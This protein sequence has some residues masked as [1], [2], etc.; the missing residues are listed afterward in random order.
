[1]ADKADDLEVASTLADSGEHRVQIRKAEL[2]SSEQFELLGVLGVGGMGEV[3][4]AY[5]LTLKRHVALKIL[6]GATPEL[7]ERLMREAQAQARVEHQNVCRVHGVG[8]IDGHPF[9]AL[10]YIEGKTL[11]EIGRELA[12]EERVRVMKDVALGLHAAHR[13]GLIHR[14]VK[15]ANILM[16]R[17]ED[18]AWKPYIADFGIARQVEAAA[19]TTTNMTSG[20]PLY[21]A[22]EQA[23]GDARK[24]DRRTDVYSLGA[25]LYELCCGRPPFVGPTA[26]ALILSVVAEEAVALRKREPSVPVDLETITMK[27]L[28]KDPQR[29][30]E[31]ARALAE[32]L[33]R[34]LDGEPILARRKSWTYR[35]VKRARKHLGLVVAASCAL[36][37][38]GVAAAV[39][40]SARRGAAAQA[41]LAQEV[42]RK[43]EKIDALMRYSALLPRHDTRREQ[44]LIRARMR[45]IEDEMARAAEIARPPGHY[46]LGR[47][48]LA[49]RNHGEAERHLRDAWARGYRAPEVAYA[50]GLVLGARYQEAMET[51]SHESEKQPRADLE[52][53]AAESFRDPALAFLKQSA[54]LELDTPEYAEA[55]M[56]LY[57]KRFEI[58]SEKARLAFERAPWLFEAQ[59]LEGDIRVLTAA[60]RHGRGDLEGAKA[61]LE[62]AGRAYTAAIAT[63]PSFVAAYVGNCRRWLIVTDL[64]ADQDRSPAEAVKAGVAACDTALETLPEDAMLAARKSS[65]WRHL[66]RYEDMHGEDPSPTFARAIESAAQAVKWDPKLTRAHFDEG[67]AH[68]GLGSYQQERGEDP[69][70]ALDRAQR[71]AERILA[72]DPESVEG[73]ELMAYTASTLADYQAA[74]GIDPRVELRRTV[75]HGERA[76]RRTPNAFHV[77]NE[78]GTAWFTLA[79]YELGIGQDPR[80]AIERA[81]PIY[82][83]VMRTQPTL[84]FGW[85]NACGVLQTRAEYE[86][87]TGGDPRPSL[88]EAVRYCQKAIDL[89]PNYAGS[90]LNLGCAHFDRA[91][92]EVERGLDPSG[93]IDKA[94]AALQAAIA[95]DKDY[96]MGWR[97]IAENQLLAARHAMAQ[98]KAPDAAFGTARSALDRAA[99]INPKDSDVWRASA[100]WYRHRAEWRLGKKQSIEDDV[101]SGL[102]AAD[103]ALLINPQLGPAAAIKGALYALGARAETDAARRATA[104]N[105]A[106]AAFRDALRLNPLVDHDHHE[107]IAEVAQD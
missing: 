35:A 63:A 84:D 69:R 11:R 65:M 14:D 74:R 88:D 12:L 93:S 66:A 34:Y 9:I 28:E 20:T 107:L 36:V 87:R 105:R 83:E 53:Q 42:G 3:H 95:V 48:Y 59:T 8:T 37:I 30:Y 76:L 21:M 81:M 39:A 101:R 52:R 10:Q 31:T 51:A 26:A 94:H 58:A 18:G 29:R 56:A 45:E 33:Q 27:C 72:I 43:V 41:R 2:L 40:L 62:S 97:Y 92:Y 49:L 103:K 50:L 75:E 102:A 73:H 16:E 68:R 44:A 23:R 77:R 13:Q 100:E 38:A 104:R 25:T 15:P 106:R 17:G 99:S 55:L 5:D 61:D 57:E 47:G 1:V 98:R 85:V 4:K 89:N 54:G 90:H 22:P 86:T 6:R 91:V 82:R 64:L 78:V 32:D 80:A 24:L 7:G 60:E 70:P 71:S 96:G 79:M 19:Q 46:A 67:L